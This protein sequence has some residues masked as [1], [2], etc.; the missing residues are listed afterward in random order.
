[1]A[2][3]GRMGIAGGDGRSS[4]PKGKLAR[5]TSTSKGRY[6]NSVF[7][8]G[9]GNGMSKS[10]SKL[11]TGSAGGR[12]SGTKLNKASSGKAAKKYG[13]GYKSAAFTGKK[14]T[15]HHKTSAFTGSSA[16]PNNAGKSPLS[17]GL[18][19]N[20]KVYKMK[21]GTGTAAGSGIFPYG[22]KS[23]IF[24]GSANRYQGLVGMAKRNAARSKAKLGNRGF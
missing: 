11:F 22:D 19:P 9:G 4:A 8:G 20:G 15:A 14:R 18:A 23:P 17:L 5:G 1:M 2:G 16:G 6:K 10:K 21:V 3:T 12:R 24:G 13:S 7:T